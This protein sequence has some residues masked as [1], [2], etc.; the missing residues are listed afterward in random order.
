MKKNRIIFAL[1]LIIVI[2]SMSL[3]F[4]RC[5]KGVDLTDEVYGIAEIYNT[6]LDKKPIIDIWDPHIGWFLYAPFL[7]LFKFVSPTLRGVVL[8]YRILYLSIAFLF[9]V[10]SHKL[11]NRK[12]PFL[13]LFPCIC[14]VPFS[15][16]QLGYN[17]AVSYI[18]VIAFCIL[19]CESIDNRLRLFIL[20]ITMGVLYLIYPTTI[21]T[22]F[23][24]FLI[25]LSDKTYR[26]NAFSY[27]LGFCLVGVLFVGWITIGL[28]DFSHFWVGLKAIISTPHEANKGAI[29][30]SFLK[31]TF[32]ERLLVFFSNKR[33]LLWTGHL[34]LVFLIAWLPQD[35]VKNKKSILLLYEWC[36]FILLSVVETFLGGNIAA[37]SRQGY[38]CFDVF[39]ST[40]IFEILH[41]KLINKSSKYLLFL[42]CSWIITYCFTS[43]NK[44]LF[45]AIDAASVIIVFNTCIVLCEDYTVSY[46]TTTFHQFM[47][48]I[49]IR[50]AEA[51]N[52]P[53]NYSISM[54][55]SF[56][57]FYEQLFTR[58]VEE[59]AYLQAS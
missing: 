7:K 38:I 29:N 46:C 48:K 26:R 52:I 27:L 17:A 49:V 3:M 24:L 41:W 32:L 39:L 47:I 15:I 54:P 56:E 5:T 34:L 53:G 37:I 6:A 28:S 44:N 1:S 30:L 23:F 58:K 33:Q 18:L 43:D 22:G 4:Y 45:F 25:F 9:L 21:A 8:Y 10:L 20:G 2:I 40:V 42:V 36:I 12:K 31:I 19:L 11:A 57:Q 59:T 14:F 55:H 50:R 35:A 13:L 51:Q 16:P